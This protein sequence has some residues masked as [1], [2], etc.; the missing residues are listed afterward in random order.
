MPKMKERLKEIHDFLVSPNR[1]DLELNWIKKIW[2]IVLL[3]S[4]S[5]YVFCNFS[6]VISF[7]LF[8]DFE[9][10]NLIFLLWL[11]LLMF[12]LF[13]SFEGFG[14]KIRSHQERKREDM[15]LN[16]LTK[17]VIADSNSVPSIADLE[18]KIK[19]IQKDSNDELL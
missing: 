8:D 15:E 6:E 1:T 17:D 10:D 7:T 11:V 16:Q 18:D 5:L 19:N 2:F 9:G 4:T 12:P 14:L 3:T 13:D